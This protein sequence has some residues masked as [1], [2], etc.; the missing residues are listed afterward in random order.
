MAIIDKS[1]YLHWELGEKKVG[2][3]L[4]DFERI[5]DAAR[6]ESIPD[7]IDLAA[8]FTGKH[9]TFRGRPIMLPHHGSQLHPFRRSIIAGAS[10]GRRFVGPRVD[11]HPP[12]IFWLCRAPVGRRSRGKMR[13]RAVRKMSIARA[14]SW[15]STVWP[16]SASILTS[17]PPFSRSK[18]SVNDLQRWPRWIRYPTERDQ[19]WRRRRRVPPS[20]LRLRKA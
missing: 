13:I 12:Q 10:Y 14:D 6:P 5:G 16:L 17:C 15:V 2:N 20:G 18:R 11:A 7:L 3:L 19:L 4:N 1:G 9:R 8:N